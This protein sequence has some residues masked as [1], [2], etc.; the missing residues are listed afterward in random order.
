MCVIVIKPS[1]SSLKRV[2][3]SNSRV[4]DLGSRTEGDVAI[5]FEA[6]PGFQPDRKAAPLRR[7]RESQS[8][9]KRVLVSNKDIATLIELVYRLG[10]AILF[11]ASPGFQHRQAA[12]L[13]WGRVESR[14]PL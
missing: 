14:N 3:V 10:V 8:S 1:Q 2:L 5:L 9:L 13:R 11:E 12:P 4:R 6:S 7:G